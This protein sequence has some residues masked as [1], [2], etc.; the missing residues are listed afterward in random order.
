M[1]G[2]IDYTAILPQPLPILD[3]ILS[4]DKSSSPRESR[5]PVE[6]GIRDAILS[7]NRSGV[8]AL[9]KSLAGGASFR[10]LVSVVNSSLAE[11][12]RFRF[13]ISDRDLPSFSVIG[14]PVCTEMGID[15]TIPNRLATPS[16]LLKCYSKLDR[17]RGIP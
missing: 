8:T 16:I 6:A 9:D 5:A 3:P 4:N 2:C 11:S 7:G 10:F 14:L 17:I 1:K 13:P 15:W 12:C